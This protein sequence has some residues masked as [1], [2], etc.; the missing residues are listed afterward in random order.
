METVK[1]MQKTL[2]WTS[3]IM[4]GLGIISMCYGQ[5][6]DGLLCNLIGGTWFLGY[7]VCSQVLKIKQKGK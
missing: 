3:T 7:E 6:I 4:I 2:L 5:I 1:Q